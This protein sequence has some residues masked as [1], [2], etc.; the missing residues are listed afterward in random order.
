MG[1]FFTVRSLLI[2]VILPILATIF[3]QPWNP[4]D[5]PCRLIEL[6][7]SIGLLSAVKH[8]YL[9]C[10]MP[11]FVGRIRLKRRI[12]DQFKA[13]LSGNMIRLLQ[14]DPEMFRPD[15]D[16]MKV[17]AVACHIHDLDGMINR[18]K[19][20]PRRLMSIINRTI[21]LARNSIINNDGLMGR[22]SRDQIIAV[23]GAPI[24]TDK[25]VTSAISTAIELSNLIEKTDPLVPKD[26]TI[27][28]GMGISFG[29]VLVGNIGMDGHAEYGCMGSAIR[30]AGVLSEKSRE[31][32]VAILASKEIVG[33][34]NDHV[35]KVE[36]D[37]IKLGD[38][39]AGLPIYAIIGYGKS[40]GTPLQIS[41]C[42]S[43]HA[44]FLTAYRDQRWDMA[45]VIGNSLRTAWNGRLKAYYEMMVL[46]CKAFKENPPGQNWDG[47]YRGN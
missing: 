23:W 21:D 2:G 28:V 42:Y 18:G 13:V 27:S 26:L 10:R 17:C 29:E 16:T 3:I 15:G 31:Y 12:D 33:R 40:I 36:L 35:I 46:R 14:K 19:S 47:I 4:T 6:A 5:V 32:H 43:Q 9:R 41:T 20:D 39:P 22:Y 1:R 38:H 34:I 30:I 45:V 8:G 24:G 44:K 11:E 25:T 7:V 37:T